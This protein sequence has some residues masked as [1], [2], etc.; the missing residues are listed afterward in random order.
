MK[1]REYSKELAERIAGFLESRSGYPF[2]DRSEGTFLFFAYTEFIKKEIM[3][4]IF[5]S[6]NRYDVWAE[7][8]YEISTMMPSWIYEIPRNLNHD[9]KSGDLRLL[10]DCKEACCKEVG[11]C[12]RDADIRWLAQL[13]DFILFCNYYHNCRFEIDDDDFGDI[14]VRYRVSVDCT[15][16]VPSCGMLENSIIEPLDRMIRISKGL[17]RFANDTDTRL[18][19]VRFDD[20]SNGMFHF[21]HIKGIVDDYS[22]I[23]DVTDPHVCYDESFWDYQPE[24]DFGNSH[25]EDHE[26]GSKNNGPSHVTVAK[27]EG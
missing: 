24:L 1:Q 4:R 26:K 22:I 13:K 8:P 23:D 9:E 27:K 18:S 16:I 15:D 5:V 7:Y 19:D 14:T 21:P 25:E 12:K 20:I 6:K 3:F 17:E 10:Q 2:R 11:Y